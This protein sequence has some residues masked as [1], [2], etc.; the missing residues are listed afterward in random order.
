MIEVDGASFRD[1]QRELMAM[2]P[3]VRKE[4]NRGLKDVLTRRILPDAKS[5]ASWSSR[6]PGQIKPQVTTTR[7]AL[8]V[9]GRRVPHAYP[10]E[11]LAKG[12][13]GR[14]RPSFRHPVFGRRSR[15][16]QTW[17]WVQQSTRPFLV[18]AFDKNRQAAADEASKAIDAA[19]RR[20][21]FR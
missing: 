7:M 20:V 11:G 4:L 3:D 10:F 1:F 18:P 19:A 6:I 9:P 8:R 12:E 14:T 13:L 16:R 2:A 21:G 15:P 17:T 5:N